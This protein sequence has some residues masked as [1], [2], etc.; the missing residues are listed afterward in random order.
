ML[1]WF[2]YRWYRNIKYFKTIYESFSFVKSAFCFLILVPEINKCF[3]TLFVLTQSFVV[4][5][6][7]SFWYENVFQS[8]RASKQT[9]FSIWLW[10]TQ[11]C[12]TFF[13]FLVATSISFLF[14]LASTKLHHNATISIFLMFLRKKNSHNSRWNNFYPLW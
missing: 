13:S 4:N 9:V 14:T 6:L 12:I 2:L 3:F 5:M 1:Q 8:Q 10:E 7:C 11:K